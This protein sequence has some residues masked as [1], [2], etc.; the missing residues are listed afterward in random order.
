MLSCFL[1]EKKKVIWVLRV[2]RVLVCNTLQLI[3]LTFVLSLSFFV[4]IINNNNL[5]VSS[6]AGGRQT[7]HWVLTVTNTDVSITRQL[8]SYLCSCPCSLVCSLVRAT[9]FTWSSLHS[10]K[11]C[12]LPFVLRLAC[13]AAESRGPM[14]TWMHSKL[15]SSVLLS[16]PHPLFTSLNFL[17]LVLVPFFFRS[18]FVCKRVLLAPSE[19]VSLVHTADGLE[20]CLV[21]YLLGNGWRE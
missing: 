16:T 4:I 14:S 6:E 1:Q 10:M 18:V 12:L 3:L 8:H 9:E 11:S 21:I 2:L 13:Q 17:M 20:K 15:A 5:W 19:T 7:S